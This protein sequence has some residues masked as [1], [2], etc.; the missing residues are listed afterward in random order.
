M[1]IN[2]KK[3]LDPLIRVISV[4]IAFF[5]S[6]PEKAKVLWEK[7]KELWIKAR[8]FAKTKNIS[9]K[10]FTI[11]SAAAAFVIVVVLVLICIPRSDDPIYLIPESNIEAICDE[12][13]EQTI[14]IANGK[15]TGKVI[16]GDYD[17]I[18]SSLDGKV[19]LLLADEDRVLYAYYKKSLIKIDENIESCKISAE[20]TAV[21]YIT[22]D[23][24]LVL[25]T[26]KNKKSKTICD[27]LYSTN[28]SYYHISPDGKSVAYTVD[29][30]DEFTLCVYTGGKEKVIADNAIP[31]GL[32][33][34]A[35]L[36]YYYNSEKS[37]FY[38][39]KSGKDPVK[40]AGDLYSFGSVTITF[41]TDHTQALFIADY[42]SY[43]TDN[44]SEKH[45][46]SS[47]TI[48]Q[49]GQ[50]YISGQITTSSMYDFTEKYFIDSNYK[51]Y[52][53]DKKFETTSIESNV[54]SL[55]TTV[56][57]DIIYF[58]KINGDL[59]RG[60]GF[61]GKC[62]EIADEVK[63]FEITSDGKACYYVDDDET[64]YYLKK[65]GKSKKV[66]DDVYSIQITH[67]DRALFITDY[68]SN[69]GGT[70]YSSYNGKSKKLI[71]DEVS[72]FI[73]TSTCAYYNLH[74]D[75][76]GVYDI[77]SATKKAK[78]SLLLSEF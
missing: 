58:L 20:G 16:D 61:G 14:I 76:K 11:A 34:K 30:G 64:L 1:K 60:K 72:S 59:Y 23:G 70:L 31:Y 7:A 37:A 39:I 18:E 62:E 67:D 33:D 38:V 6:L 44:G 73:T 35:K 43:I 65:S 47:N 4:I 42:K 55:Q 13:K 24:E 15:N 68:S 77:Y 27:E 21:A 12:D 46:I 8:E 2:A 29:D 69:E 63:Q 32:S 78:F 52:Y 56:S 75:E 53:I 17:Y 3:L 49:I 57:G 19:M 9:E 48:Y 74:T 10:V 45:K 51:L 28:Y 50:Y 54:Y 36:V 5:K 66:A 41:N 25:Y 22:S 40:L 71:S 26:L